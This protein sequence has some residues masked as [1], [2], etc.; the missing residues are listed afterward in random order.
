MINLSGGS[1]LLTRMAQL[2]GTNLDDMYEIY[3]AI[4]TKFSIY[5]IYSGMLETSINGYPILNGGL[6]PRLCNIIG[7]SA[8]G[9]TTLLVG[10][11]TSAVDYIKS[12]FGDGYS[13]L[14]Y[15]DV[16]KNLNKNRFCEVSHWSNADYQLRCSYSSEDISL[17]DLANMIIK[18]ADIKTKYRKDYLLP[19]GIRDIDGREV[20]FLAP[21]Y[22]CLD[23]VAAVNTDGV[24]EMMQNDKAGEVKDLDTLANNTEAMRDAKAWTIF[25]R[26]IKPWLDKANIGLYCIN[27]K[28]KETK[29]SMFD[30]ETRYLP[31]LG[32]GEKLKGGKEF[33]FQS[34]N[35][36]DLSSGEKFDD[37]NPVYGPDVFGFST[38][39]SFV[40]SKTSMEGVKFPMVFDLNRGYMPEL[41]DME[42]LYQKKFGIDGSIKMSLDVLPEVSFTRR[43][44][45]QTIEEYPQL[46]RAIQFTAKY[47]ASMDMLYHMPPVSL[48][49]L[50]TNV[51]LEQ[52][53]SILYG[54]TRPYDKDIVDDPYKNFASLAIANQHY[55][56]FG[57]AIVD[58]TL[59]VVNNQNI[60]QASD[61][62]T[63]VTTQGVTPYDAD[64]GLAR[65]ED[66]HYVFPIT[67]AEK[68]AA[69]AS[70]K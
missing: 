2:N 42:Y 46:A 4:P 16:E 68:E 70:K 15:L 55:Y 64:K 39:A 1:K 12:K 51:P 19:S 3:P 63:F 9:K 38:R 57:N 41:S 69:V 22:I 24:E 40:K 21:T 53:L 8:T 62:Y 7:E 33:I 14:I 23:S 20:M 31:F 26:K 37:R 34:Y 13:E 43:T 58:H 6:F 18:I 45:L 29:M 67:K 44:L 52:R 32:M 47:H 27:H 10:L 66:G 25:V 30:K 11:A 61:G 36:L 35:I 49:D 50:G 59:D 5:N 65:V 28:T 60:E 17:L 48:K 54:F 56:N